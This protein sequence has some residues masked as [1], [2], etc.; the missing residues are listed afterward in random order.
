MTIAR[1]VIEAIVA[2]A[3]ESAPAE[4]CGL[5]IGRPGAVTEAARA[6]NISDRPTRYLLDP[7]DHIDVRRACRQR[8]L[9]IV[10]FYHSH[11]RPPAEPS[12]TDQIEASYSDHLYLIVALGPADPEIGLFRFAGRNFRREAFVTLG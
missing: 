5:L 12:E 10:G 7:K 4:C 11:P 6:R 1:A 9:E 8:D 3:R 2:H